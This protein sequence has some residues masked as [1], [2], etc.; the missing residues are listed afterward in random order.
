MSS[1]LC[2]DNIALE[3]KNVHSLIDK[4]EIIFIDEAYSNLLNLIHE[5][6]DIFVKMTYEIGH[7]ISKSNIS[8]MHKLIESYNNMESFDI[9]RKL[10][11]STKV[12]EKH[13]Q[14]ER[15]QNF[16]IIFEDQESKVCCNERCSIF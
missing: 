11:I 1:L 16:K 2:S 14:N 7:S 3:C 9:L 4:G 8:K 12:T 5:F 15:D 6:L 10:K 13:Q